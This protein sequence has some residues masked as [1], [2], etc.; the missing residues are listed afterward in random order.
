MA[1]AYG[2][3]ESN[4]LFGASALATWIGVLFVV[5]LPSWDSAGPQHIHFERTSRLGGAAVLFGY[6]IALGIALTQQ[7]I[8]ILPA[9]PL[10]IAA[11]PVFVVGLWEDVAHRVPPRRRLLAAL[12]SAA[13]ASAFADGIVTRLDLPYVDGWLA[14]LPLAVP[15]TLFMVAGACNAFNIIDGSHGLAGGTAL[16]SFFGIAILAWNAGDDLVLAQAGAMLGAL[17]SFRLWNYPRGK[18]FLGDAGAYFIGFMYAQ[19]SIQLIARNTG[20]SA[21][22]VI[23]LAAY[24]IVEVLYSIYRRKMIRHTAAM[25]PDVLHLHSLLYVCVLLFAQRRTPGDRRESVWTCVYPSGERRRPMRGANARV[26]PLLWLHG[27]VCLAG[28]L[29]FHAATGALISVICLYGGLY[30]LCY[31]SAVRLSGSGSG[32]PM[33]NESSRAAK[34]VALGPSRAM[35]PPGATE[36]PRAAV[37]LS[38]AMELPR[39]AER[40]TAQM[41]APL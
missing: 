7:L 29:Y 10:L 23:A 15:V 27:C 17:V 36:L 2:L 35:E 24:P 14:Y 34:A 40:S 5:R 1:A 41:G 39:A 26:A 19:L 12:V 33:N 9:L 30:F 25:Q 13:V 4:V 28:A 37:E 6:V 8:A 18:V 21:W 3:L 31:L 16:L 22:F 32:L 38:T 11:L 20:I